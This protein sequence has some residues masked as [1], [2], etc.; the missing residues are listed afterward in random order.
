MGPARQR[1][2]AL[3]RGLR[4]KAEE[5]RRAQGLS[6]SQRTVVRELKTSGGGGARQ[7]AGFSGQRISDWAPKEPSRLVIPQARSDDQAVALAALYAAWAGVPPPGRELRD[8]LE[9]ARDEEERRR[10]EGGAVPPPVGHRIVREHTAGELEVSEASPP[11]RPEPAARL[12]RT[13]SPTRSPVGSPTPYLTRDHDRALR[14]Y[15]T[16]AA[17]GGSSVLAVL[18][19]DSSTGKTRAMYEAVREVAPDHRLLRPPSARSLLTLLAEDEVRDGCVLWLNEFQRILHDREGDE[20]AVELTE[21]LQRQPGIVAVATLWEDPYWRD[22]TVQGLPRDPSRHTRSLLTG[23]H[24]R[25]FRV[26]RELTADERAR[27]R[28]LAHDSGDA[29]LTAAGGAGAADGQVVQHLSGGP[30]LLDAYLSG[31]GGHFTSREHALVTVALAARRLGHQAPFPEQLLAAAADGDLAPHERASRADWAGPELDALTGGVRSDGSRADIRRTLT[32]LRALRESAGAPPGYEPADYLLQHTA[33]PRRGRE[34]SAALWEALVRHTKDLEDLHRLQAAA[35]KRGL[36]RYALRLDRRAA[37]AGTS[38]ACVRIV[39]RTARHPDAARAAAWAAAHVDVSDVP[40]VARLFPALLA[41]GFQASVD[42]LARRL[43]AAA[44]PSDVGAVGALVVRLGKGGVSAEIAAAL[45]DSLEAHLDRVDPDAI[46]PALTDL[47]QGPAQRLVRPLAHRAADRA[48]LTDVWRV[49]RLMHQLHRAGASEAMATLTTRLVAQAPHMAPDDLPLLME[50]LRQVGAEQAVD[51]LLA[52]D[53]AARIGL[54]QADVVLCLL[55][56]LREAGDAD[57]VRTLLGRS[58]ARHVDVIGD[59]DFYDIGSVLCELL[60]EFGRLGAEEECAV[61][62]DR[63]AAGIGM[64]APD[65]VA[66]LLDLFHSTGR[67]ENVRRLLA[68]RPM[69]EVDYEDPTELRSLLETLLRLGTSAEFD[70]LTSAVVSHVD[71]TDADF[72]AEAVGVLWETGG[73]RGIAPLLE[74]ASAH[75]PYED[76]AFLVRLLSL[77]GAEDAALRLARHIARHVESPGVDTMDRLLWFFTEADASEAVGI[78]LDRG[79]LDRLDT[80]APAEPWA[81]ADLLNS[82][83]EAERLEDARRFADRAAAGIPLSDIY[84]IGNLLTAMTAHDLPGPRETL[85]RRA[86][87]GA[88]LTHMNGVAELIEAFLEAGATDAVDELLRRDPLAR[89]DRAL[90]TEACH[91]A[92]LTALHKV[93]SPQAADFAQQA[94]DTGRL[95]LDRRPPYGLNPDGHPAAPWSWGDEESAAATASRAS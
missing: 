62:A 40:A 34:G 14:E 49:G 28:K 79:L 41:S 11:G 46:G 56:V 63:L 23:A 30:E 70:E 24:A 4:E 81:L 42:A 10:R 31:P 71:I 93:G 75:R 85:I 65:T 60:T 3:M 25:R 19:G 88:A 26:P 59:P 18:T 78:L 92:L 22:F 32:P 29:R 2:W 44:D 61:L 53:P 45:V 54:T 5:V 86:A 87:A 52:L 36:F 47:V 84:G 16:S 69:A 9:Q 8:L 17:A 13:P 33:R 72:V 80:A 27:W 12:S 50:R 15:L 91:E 35:W 89:T 43:L 38:D 1:L 66:K 37:I 21:V 76:M 48:D 39:Q 58:P 74:R 20:A 57:G 90:A 73:E 95:S 7:L 55:Q 83:H 6:A 67:G 68:R 64:E 94:R 51:A 82:L 77:V